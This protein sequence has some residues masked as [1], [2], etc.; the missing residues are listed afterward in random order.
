MLK[1]LWLQAKP[2]AGKLVIGTIALLIAST[3]NLLVVCLSSLH[4]LS[5]YFYMMLISEVCLLFW[6]QPKFGG[7]IIDIV[8]RDAKTP[9]QQS[10][11]IL[12]VRNAVIIILLIVVVG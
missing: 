12:A 5:S 8:S 11:S 1:M 7:M 6:L 2:D 10:E 3:T 4:L 9:E